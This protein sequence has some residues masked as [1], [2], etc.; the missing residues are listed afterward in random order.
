[1]ARPAGQYLGS[2]GAQ[3]YSIEGNMGLQ[4]LGNTQYVDAQSA[5]APSGPHIPPRAVMFGRTK[6]VYT[7]RQEAQ[8][9]AV[10][11]HKM[12][13]LQAQGQFTTRGRAAFADDAIAPKT[14]AT[15]AGVGL[16]GL[17]GALLAAALL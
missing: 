12:A 2:L 6:L 16:G 5:G 3:L 15:L 13:L 4:G 11:A 10:V 8:R 7:L 1:M 17:A 14:A 9:Q